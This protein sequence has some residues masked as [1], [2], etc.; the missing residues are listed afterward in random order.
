MS[1]IVVLPNTGTNKFGPQTLV[2]EAQTFFYRTGNLY[3]SQT[4][5]GKLSRKQNRKR[6]RKKEEAN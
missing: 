5:V 6:K 1:Y 2:A 3:I 4:H